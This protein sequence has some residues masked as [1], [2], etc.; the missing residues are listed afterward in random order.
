MKPLNRL[1][2]CFASALLLNAG[3]KPAF[4]LVLD[5]V[6]GEWT[7]VTGGSN[8][9]GLGTNEVRF[10]IPL[11][12][13]Q[14]GLR[15]DGSAP[16]P[17]ALSVGADF[18]LGTLTHF[19]VPTEGEA[20]TAATLAISLQLSN[21]TPVAAGPL[22]FLFGI[23]ETDNEFPCPAFQQSGTPCDDR[24]SFPSALPGV[25]FALDGVAHTLQLVGFLSGGVQALDFITEEGLSN[26][27]SLVARIIP[28][29]APDVTVPEPHTVLLLGIGFLGL[30]Y[31][32][33]YGR[34]G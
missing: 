13:E 23:D 33:R 19:N 31:R 6:V 32:C 26:S 29:P 28:T 25:S 8:V 12:T 11:D 30:L 27:A 5:S 18:N 7:S 9:I 2:L 24:I 21:G 34:A 3:I 16:P 17:S 22:N 15:F 20:V 1:F 4:P 14:A 10:G